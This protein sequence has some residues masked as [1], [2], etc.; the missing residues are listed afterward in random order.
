MGGNKTRREKGRVWTRRELALALPKRASGG[1][2]HLW[3]S[4]PLAVP[5]Y[6]NTASLPKSRNTKLPVAITPPSPC[7]LL[8]ASQNL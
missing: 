2:I 5:D 3:L 7:F 1:F 6:R 4:V 8:L